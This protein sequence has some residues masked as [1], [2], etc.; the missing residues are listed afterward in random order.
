MKEGPS[1]QPDLEGPG[2]LYVRKVQYTKENI[3]HQKT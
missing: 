1:Q 3:L 2:I